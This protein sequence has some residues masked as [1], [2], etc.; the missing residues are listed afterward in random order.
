MDHLPGLGAVRAASLKAPALGAGRTAAFR[1]KARAS[2]HRTTHQRFIE[3]HKAWQR[4]PKNSVPRNTVQKHH[5]NQRCASPSVTRVPFRRR[6]SPRID[7]TMTPQLCWSRIGTKSYRHIKPLTDCGFG[8]AAWPL[9]SHRLRRIPRA[10]QRRSPAISCSIPLI[11]PC[12][13][14]VEA[15]CSKFVTIR[16]KCRLSRASRCVSYYL[17]RFQI[18][19]GAITLKDDSY[20]DGDWKVQQREVDRANR[21][22]HSIRFALIVNVTSPSVQR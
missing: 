6:H 16:P 22:S 18:V 2:W 3:R 14:I 12:S 10:S 15:W 4:R 11:V 19:V 20:S 7:L 17:N 21:V 5:P 1:D 8:W 9:R 13:E